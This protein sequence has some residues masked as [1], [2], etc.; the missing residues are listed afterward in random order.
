MWYLERSNIGVLSSSVQS[1]SINIF[2][3]K[4]AALLAIATRVKASLFSVYVIHFV[5]DAVSGAG[6]DVVF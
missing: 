5:F 1:T 4:K 3:V 6:F 2:S